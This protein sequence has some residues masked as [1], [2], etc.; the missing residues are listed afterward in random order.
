[1]SQRAASGISDDL[2]DDRVAAMLGFGLSHLEPAGDEHRVVTP[3]IEQ[4]LLPDSV[5]R[6]QAL[7]PPHDQPSAHLQALGSGRER[8]V[9][10]LGDLGP[11]STT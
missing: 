4:F 3:D 10:N 9:A 6:V 5:L 11:M 7:D 2:L 1:M 8:G